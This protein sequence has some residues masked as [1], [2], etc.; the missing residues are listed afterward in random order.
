MNIRFTLR[1]ISYTTR[2][3]TINIYLDFNYSTVRRQIFIKTPVKVEKAYWNPNTQKIGKTYPNSKA[4]TELLNSEL[5][6]VL[7]I[8]NQL[9]HKGEDITPETIQSLIHHKKQGIKDLITLSKE[10][11]ELRS[12]AKPRLI[13]KLNNLVSRLKEFQNAKPLYYSHI[14]QNFINKFTQY[15]QDSS[16]KYGS[17][18][19]STINKTFSFLRQILN[20]YYSTNVVDDNFRKLKYPNGFKQKQMVFT[21]PEIKQLINYQPTIKRLQK[22][23]DLALLQLYTGLRY[24]DAIKLNDSNIY[25]N[26]LNITTKKTNQVIEIPLHKNLK[27]LIVKYNN[28]LSI[29][30]IS[31]AKYNN[32]LKELIEISGIISKAEY[33]HFVNGIM[34]TTQKF[35]YDLVGS[36]TFRRSF[37]TNAIIQ[38]IPLHVIQSITGHTT[39]KQ[40]TEYVNIAN[41]VKQ[42]EMNKLD[43]LFSVG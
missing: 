5:Q 16:S 8:I 2:I 37:I 10:Y 6:A 38:G 24:S 32:Y 22:V 31:N 11:I 9:N 27:D 29:L 14:N 28:N 15:L 25:N 18:Q 41:E 17:Q 36:H 23:K 34:V 33:I 1:N 21:Q 40:L 7:T 30:K 26:F 20:H 42:L 4:L 43:S 13:E 3:G 39:L 12:D 19:P 35:K